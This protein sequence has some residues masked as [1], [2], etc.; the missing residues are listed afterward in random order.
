MRI[1]L[2]AISPEFTVHLDDQWG[3]SLSGKGKS[4]RKEHSLN[5]SEALLALLLLRLSPES[6]CASAAHATVFARRTSLLWELWVIQV[7]REFLMW[8]SV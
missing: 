8:V 2:L 3:E 6:A 7:A 4:N 5:H 1:A